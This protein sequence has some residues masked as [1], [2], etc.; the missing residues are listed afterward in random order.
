MALS[1]TEIKQFILWAKKNKIQQ[2]KVGEVEVLFSQ[3][4]F[5]VP[6]REVPMFIDPEQIEKHA[7]AELEEV[8]FHSST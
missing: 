7:Q 6:T 4:A 2:V 3:K 5:E 8:M 1:L